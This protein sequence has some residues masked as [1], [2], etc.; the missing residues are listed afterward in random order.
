MILS[1]LVVCVMNA[2]FRVLFIVNKKKLHYKF[3]LTDLYK[4][5]STK[6]NLGY[7]YYIF[8]H[9]FYIIFNIYE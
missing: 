2:Y 4:T 1:S 9:K 6:Y 7:D 8:I 5:I 3:S